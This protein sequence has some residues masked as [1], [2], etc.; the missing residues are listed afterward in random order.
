MIIEPI[1]AATTEKQIEEI[2]CAIG[3]GH[4]DD[5]PCF[6]CL[7]HRMSW[8]QEDEN[9]AGFLQVDLSRHLQYRAY[10]RKDDF[11]R[12]AHADSARS[13]PPLPDSCRVFFPEWQAII[14]HTAA[15]SPA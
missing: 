3:E 6:P 2:E 12:T 8:S 7:V 5:E 11:R 1:V 4:R 10:D 9:S 13:T 14:K 15:C